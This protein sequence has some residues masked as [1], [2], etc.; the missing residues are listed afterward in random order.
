MSE[1]EPAQRSEMPALDLD[2]DPVALS[3]DDETPAPPEIMDV[4]GSLLEKR[5]RTEKDLAGRL[6][7]RGYDAPEVE[8][9]VESLKRLRLVDDDAFA[10]TWLESRKGAKSMG[11]SG[12]VAMLVQ[13]GLEREAAEAA[14]EASGYDEATAAIEFA[15]ANLR[16][17]S[18]LSPTRQAAKLQRML[19][20]RGFEEA[21]IETAVEAILPPEGWD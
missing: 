18:G 16:R 8:A 1:A 20:S 7:D 15:R 14:V 13:K 17:L 3:L 12:L 19:I 9:A 4:A 5:A 21:A 2:E 11:R 6:A 10:L